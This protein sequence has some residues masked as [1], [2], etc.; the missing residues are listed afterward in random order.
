MASAFHVV[1]PAVSREREIYY[2]ADVGT[3]SLAVFVE[4]PA[5]K[6]RPLN[7]VDEAVASI[8]RA[9]Y[10]TDKPETYGAAQVQLREN[11]RDM[12]TRGLIEG[13]SAVES[14]TVEV[15]FQPSPTPVSEVII[16][17]YKR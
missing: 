1:S 14:K 5:P 4:G 10:P 7:D 8:Q 2:G 13:G 11:G 15:V 17:Y 3:I 9:Q 6:K 12:V 16:P